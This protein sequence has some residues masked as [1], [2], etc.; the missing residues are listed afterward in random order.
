MDDKTKQTLRTLRALHSECIDDRLGFGTRNNEFPN[1]A[2]VTDALIHAT[3]AL[4]TLARGIEP[5]TAVDPAELRKLRALARIGE[6]YMV[7]Q[8]ATQ[9]FGAA[10]SVAS[11]MVMDKSLIAALD[12]FVAA[13]DEGKSAAGK[14]PA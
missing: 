2:D 8:A 14:P 7:K 6:V 9:M 11:A 1:F 3:L 13:C 5:V 4:E 10:G 12:D